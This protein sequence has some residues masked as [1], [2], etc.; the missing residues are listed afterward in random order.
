MLPLTDLSMD[1][2]LGAGRTVLPRARYDLLL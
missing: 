2:A 1:V